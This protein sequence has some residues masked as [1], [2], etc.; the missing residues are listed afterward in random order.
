MPLIYWFLIG[1]PIGFIYWYLILRV[2]AI[3]ANNRRQ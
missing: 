2:I 3:A 1:L